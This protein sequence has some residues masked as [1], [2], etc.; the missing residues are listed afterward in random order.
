M[1]LRA[2]RNMRDVDGRSW[3]CKRIEYSTGLA[4]DAGRGWQKLRMQADGILDINLSRREVPCHWICAPEDNRQE[5]VVG[6][7]SGILLDLLL[8][9]HEQHAVLQQQFQ[10]TG[11]RGLYQGASEQGLQEVIPWIAAV[12]RGLHDALGEL[13]ERQVEEL[14][15]LALVRCDEHLP[16]QDL[17]LNVTVDVHP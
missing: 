5:H 14:L 2:W 16:A 7:A 3:A 4:Q 1:A 11:D 10:T 17:V 6:V 13:H 9:V 8:A 12:P 15:H